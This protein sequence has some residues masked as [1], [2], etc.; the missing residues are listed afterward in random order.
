MSNDHAAAPAPA[1]T[2]ERQCLFLHWLERTRSV[3]RA[4]AAAGL[5]REGAYRLRARDPAGLFALLWADIMRR[6]F[7]IMWGHRAGPLL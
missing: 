2:P 4:A 1:W 6:P 3:S 5:S 7:R